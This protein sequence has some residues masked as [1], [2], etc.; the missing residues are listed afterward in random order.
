MKC[1]E[2]VFLFH[3]FLIISLGCNQYFEHLADM[4][5]KKQLILNCTRNS[6][7]QI[8][9]S[10]KRI[11]ISIVNVYQSFHCVFLVNSWSRE[12]CVKSGKC[13]EILN[14]GLAKLIIKST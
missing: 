7:G 5:D 2:H 8:K 4:Q 3:L 6:L 13:L 9:L 1:L 10:G 14:P 11:A 12:R